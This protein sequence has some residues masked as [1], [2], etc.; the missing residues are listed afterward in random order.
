MPSLPEEHVQLLRRFDPLREEI[1]RFRDFNAL[2]DSG[3]ISRVR[4]LKQLAGFFVL[5]SRRAGHGRG[6]QRRVRR[7][8]RRAFAKALGEI[9]AFAQALDEM[10]G[11][12][13]STVDGVEVTVEHVA[14]I[15]AERNAAGRLWQR[16]GK[17]PPRVE[18]EKRTRPAPADSQIAADAQAAETSAPSRRCGCGRE[19]RARCSGAKRPLQLPG[20]PA[21]GHYAR[22]KFRRKKASCAA[23]KNPFASLSAW[24]TRNIARSCPC[25]SST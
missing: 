8:I 1:A 21:S 6:L 9:K 2:I 7:E 25:G 18:A 22:N 19:S 11:S 23:W 20:V 10:G 16:A 14:A 12:I 3:I 13:L 5:S 15:E 4:E 24:P 17:I